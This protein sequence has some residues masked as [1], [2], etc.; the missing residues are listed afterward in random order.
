M[1][2]R[3]RASSASYKASSR[4]TEP[5]AR[6]SP[7]PAKERAGNNLA[8]S[9]GKRAVVKSAETLPP[10]RPQSPSRP[11]ERD[12]GPAD[13]GAWRRTTAPANGAAAQG[14]AAGLQVVKKP[15]II[16]EPSVV[17]TIHVLG[18]TMRFNTHPGP[19]VFTMR[20]KPGPPI[21]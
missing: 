20:Y 1:K 19:E 7:R 9:A 14:V 17:N 2:L 3:P 12:F 15:V 16:K 11:P 4:R 5:A 21:Y 8:R 10:G 13:G 18:S 6:V